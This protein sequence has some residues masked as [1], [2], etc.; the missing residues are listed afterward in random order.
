MVQGGCDSS[1]QRQVRVAQPQEPGQLPDETFCARD[2]IICNA[3]EEHGNYWRLSSCLASTARSPVR[4]TAVPCVLPLIVRTQ[5]RLG[6]Q[7]PRAGRRSILLQCPRGMLR[8]ASPSSAVEF[9]ARPVPLEQSL[10]RL[11][12]LVREADFPILCQPGVFVTAAPMFPRFTPSI[13]RQRAHGA[14]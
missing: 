10:S 13:I 12:D 6:Q 14:L 9:H 2:I 7:N 4:V 1:C 11:F 8:C 3:C 5:L